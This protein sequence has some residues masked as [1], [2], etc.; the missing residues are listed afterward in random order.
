[1]KKY[2]IVV[3]LVLIGFVMGCNHSNTPEASKAPES[4]ETPKAPD[5]PEALTVTSLPANIAEYDMVMLD[6]GKLYFYNTATSVMVPMEAEKDSVVNA[7]FEPDI[8]YYCV[9]KDN[10]I[11]LRSIDLTQPDPQPKHLADWGV[12][13]EDCVTETYGTVSPLYCYRNR[14]TLGLYHNFDWD[15]YWFNKQ[16]LYNLETG[17]ITD[18]T[19]E[20]EE[21]GSAMQSE[22]EE[23]NAHYTSTANKLQ[24]YLKQIEGQYYMTD[25]NDGNNVCLT[26][27]INCASY[28]SSPEYYEG[29][30][31]EY[32]SSSPDNLKV[33][34]A[35]IVEW[36]DFAHGILAISSIDGKLQMPLEDTDCTGFMA[37]WLNDGS[38]VYVGE[39]PLSPDDPDYDASWH[40]RTH[41]IKRIYPDNRVEIIAHCGEF[42]MKRSPL[43]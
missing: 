10:H 33:L 37:Q 14:K 27:Q 34:Y 19:Q 26:N 43:H 3:A 5:S 42:Q 35:I 20:W 28:A 4:I 32:I 23:E 12:P 15:G 1:M 41:C 25:G 9:A 18:W 6:K 38:L 16:K 17:E 11:L 36:G 40:Y 13:Y 2:C 21:K 7:L 8:L 22:N 29:P 31:F 30:E 24:E 39:E